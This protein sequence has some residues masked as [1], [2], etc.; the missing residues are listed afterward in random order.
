MYICPLCKQYSMN[1][2]EG[3][4]GHF[5]GGTFTSLRRLIQYYKSI[6]T[7]ASKIFQDTLKLWHR[8]VVLSCRLICLALIGLPGVAHFSGGI[9]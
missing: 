2:T 4:S 6:H 3:A 5:F 7:L 9:S 1:Y 8:Y